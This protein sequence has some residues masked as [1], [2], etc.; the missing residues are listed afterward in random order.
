MTGVSLF[1]RGN[2]LQ[3]R[4][5]LTI[6]GNLLQIARKSCQVRMEVDSRVKVR[7]TPLGTMASAEESK[8]MEGGVLSLLERRLCPG[9]QIPHHW[10]SKDHVQEFRVGNATEVANSS[11]WTLLESPVWIHGGFPMLASQANTNH[12]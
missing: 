12:I 4:R 11:D 2:N 8:V 9:P 6:T 3:P 5:I 7:G 10:S 1:N